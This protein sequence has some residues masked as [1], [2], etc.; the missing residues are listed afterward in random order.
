MSPPS[1]S[2]N[3]ENYP[4]HTRAVRCEDT[5]KFVRVYKRHTK[6]TEG[7]EITDAEA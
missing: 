7:R 3:P 1:R 5:W 2:R 6:Q 4:G